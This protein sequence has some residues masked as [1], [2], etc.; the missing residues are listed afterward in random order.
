MIASSLLTYFV[1]KGINVSQSVME[2]AT[3]FSP[4]KKL[5]AKLVGDVDTMSYAA[6]KKASIKICKKFNGRTN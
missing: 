5:A 3:F 1:I 4:R 6:R 2:H